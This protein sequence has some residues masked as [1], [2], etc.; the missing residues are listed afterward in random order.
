ML[1][2]KKAMPERNAPP[3]MP[4]T[5]KQ[6][7][8]ECQEVFLDVFSECSDTGAEDRRCMAAAMQAAIEHEEGYEDEEPL[9]EDD[10][11]LL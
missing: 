9:P 8:P 3:M 5:V 7:S 1:P 4:D 6:M 11:D 10:E 2:R